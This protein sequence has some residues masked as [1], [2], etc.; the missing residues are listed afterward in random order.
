MTDCL[1]GAINYVAV[2]LG[3]RAFVRKIRRCS[4]PRAEAADTLSKFDMARFRRLVETADKFPRPIPRVVTTWIQKP[5]VDLD[6][7]LKIVLELK[8]MGHNVYDSMI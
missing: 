4:T 1:L 5:T 6:L 3:T 2:A 7:G 8:S